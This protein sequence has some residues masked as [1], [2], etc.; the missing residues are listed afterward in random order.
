MNRKILIADDDS[1]ILK[2][3]QIN[4]EKN[5]YDVVTAS[6]GYEVIDKLAS[7]K[8]DLILLDINMPKMT[9]LEILSSIKENPV[10]RDIPVI[11]VTAE[12]EGTVFEQA[13]ERQADGYIVKPFKI[14]YLLD[15]IRHLLK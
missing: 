13:V 6:D 5:E 10:T 14:D 9:G 7:E 1:D 2:F 15:K 3:I 4:L 8:P 12:S 11:M